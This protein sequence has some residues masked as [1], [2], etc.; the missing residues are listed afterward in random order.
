MTTFGKVRWRGKES[1]ELHLRP[2]E[3]RRVVVK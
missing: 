1:R 3:P 2:G